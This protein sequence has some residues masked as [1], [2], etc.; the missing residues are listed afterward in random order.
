MRA[1]P[2]AAVLVVAACSGS[3]AV[4][5]PD[6]AMAAASGV[7]LEELTRGRQVYVTSCSGCHRLYRI[8]EFDRV[9]WESAVRDM[10]PKAKL[11]PAGRDEL[12]GYLRAAAR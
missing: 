6:A 8:D 1:A 11:A 10:A 4:P 7:G 2:L 9:G 12:L 5:R 3:G